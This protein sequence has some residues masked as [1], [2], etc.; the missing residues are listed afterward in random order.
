M[1]RSY[2]MTGGT[3]SC[4]SVPP[5]GRTKLPPSRCRCGYT[6]VELMVTLVIVTV[7]AAT[8]G[9]FFARLLSLQE[10]EREEAYIREKLVD[11]CGAVADDLS[12]ASSF[13]M[14]TSLVQRDIIVAYRQETGGVSLETGRVSR[15]AQLVLTT[16]ATNR[17]AALNVFSHEP[18]GLRRSLSRSLEGDAPL[19]PLAGELVSCTLTPFN[20]AI[21]EEDG[22]QT[23]DAALGYLQVTARYTVRNEDG[24][25]EAKTATAGRVVRLW[26]RQ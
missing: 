11:V 19:M 25:D 17:A 7:L 1:E 8:V 3:R 10:R 26:N 20:A 9:M 12:I 21:T 6:I 14:R 22:I 24:E 13:S 2:Q 23:S 5:D 15:V 4:A 16:S 18:E